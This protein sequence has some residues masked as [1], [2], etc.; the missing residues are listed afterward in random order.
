[1]FPKSVDFSSYSESLKEIE[2]PSTLLGSLDWHY[3]TCRMWAPIAGNRFQRPVGQT[4]AAWISHRSLVSN[5][6]YRLKLKNQITSS[7]RNAPIYCPG[8]LISNT[9]SL[10]SDPQISLFKVSIDLSIFVFSSLSLLNACVLCQFF[11]KF[12]EVFFPWSF[13]SSGCCCLL[14]LLFASCWVLIGTDSLHF[15]GLG[16]LYF[17]VLSCLG[18]EGW[19]TQFL[20]NFVWL[21]ELQLKLKWN[22]GLITPDISCV[23]V[24]LFVFFIFIFYSWVSSIIRMGTN[25]KQVNGLLSVEF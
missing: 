7:Q 9:P 14:F 3:W 5:V 4:M 23:C 12:L 19:I 13:I 16:I 6:A 21:V 22:L 20:H 17:W 11:F 1:M 18:V 15:S 8:A 2:L 10:V 24:C 25:V